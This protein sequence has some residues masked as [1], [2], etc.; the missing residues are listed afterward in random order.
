MLYGII[1]DIGVS[2]C[3]IKAQFKQANKE[4][5]VIK[6]NTHITSNNK[7][8]KNISDT[9]K[10]KDN[11]TYDKIK[12]RQL[13]I[14]KT[15]E[16]IISKFTS[17]KF[18]NNRYIVLLNKDS[19]VFSAEI[20]PIEHIVIN[21]SLDISRDNVSIGIKKRDGDICEIT[22]ISLTDNKVKIINVYTEKGISK[23]MLVTIS[24]NKIRSYLLIK[25]KSIGKSHSEV[26]NCGYKVRNNILKVIMITINEICNNEHEKVQKR[27]KK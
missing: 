1:Y 13:S 14:V 8:N 17:R 4:I 3:D 16:S 23:I 15:I 27:S 10:K 26:I 2:L 6:N 21:K 22:T 18:V 7:N 5:I 12:D 24:K 11:I 19:L 9:S 25:S 20:K